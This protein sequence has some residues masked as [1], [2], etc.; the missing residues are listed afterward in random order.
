MFIEPA[1]PQYWGQRLADWY[2]KLIYRA[3]CA[4]MMWWVK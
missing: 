2:A 4:D 3:R 1:V